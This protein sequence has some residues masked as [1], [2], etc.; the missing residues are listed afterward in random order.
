M[1]LTLTPE[2]ES[3]VLAVA[4]RRNLAPEAVIDA[5]LESL[6]RDD[7]PQDEATA[8]ETADGEQKRMRDLLA[9][10]QAQA[11]LLPPVP[12][13][14]RASGSAPEEQAFG[15]I[16]AEKYRRQG[17]TKTHMPISAPNAVVTMADLLP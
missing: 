14:Q 4:T 1:A 3:R 15:E 8:Q 5:A 16:V 13:E 7:P 10:V 12:P 6:L 17:F 9:A 11:Q 2:I